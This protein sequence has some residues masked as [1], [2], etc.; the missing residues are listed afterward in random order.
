MDIWKRLSLLI[1]NLMV[2][3]LINFGCSNTPKAIDRSIPGPQ[4]IVQPDSIRLGVVKLRDTNIVFEGSG[5]SPKTG[6]SVLIILTGPKETRV[7]AAE[8][9]I[10]PDGTFKATVTVLTKMME[11]LKADIK[12]DENFQQIVVIKEL[13]IPEGIYTVKVMSMLSKQ[14][15]ET[16]L[17]VKG[18][19]LIDRLKDFIGKLTGKIQYK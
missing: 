10:K 15:A 16:E 14:T 7:I 9:P 3:L 19:N 8:A 18:P 1:I 2:F 6:D 5:F 12:M 4:V 13:P 11:F 17:T